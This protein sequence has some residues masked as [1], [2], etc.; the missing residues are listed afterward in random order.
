MNRLRHVASVCLSLA[1]LPTL[2]ADERETIWQA[3]RQRQ[4]EAVTVSAGWRKSSMYSTA[5][6]IKL[7]RKP[8]PEAEDGYH[9]PPGY[10]VTLSLSGDRARFES[11]SAN[12]QEKLLPTID[13]YDGTRHRS[14]TNNASGV[15]REL[16]AFDGWNN[17]HMRGLFLNVRP[18]RP[19]MF[20]PDPDAWSIDDRSA[21]IDGRTC[22][23]IVRP[24]KVF[25]HRYVHRAY[26]DP[27]RE[28]VPLR[29]ESVLN[30]KLHAQVD[31][32]Y[33][34]T[35][36]PAWVAS[37]WRSVLYAGDRI[38]AQSQNDLEK[39]VLGPEI[40][41]SAF[42]I[43]YPPGTRVVIVGSEI[44]PGKLVPDVKTFAVSTKKDRVPERQAIAQ[45]TAESG[46]GPWPWALGAIGCAALGAALL[47]WRRRAAG[48]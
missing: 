45:E 29:F 24:L 41:D 36:P 27:A 37:S 34:R 46:R 32:T 9:H 26:L 21:V 16:D 23:V 12:D 13:A 31:M 35:E 20:G 25:E 38:H 19:E 43:D 4:A 48:G 28:Y 18:L 6:D 3:Y 30:G 42:T 1:F 8:P 44:P 14:L 22:V 33:A 17:I 7:G 10:R 11:F 2:R 39:V 40:P 47:I 5:P 15:V